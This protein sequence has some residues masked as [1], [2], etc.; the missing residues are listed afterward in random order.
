LGV[1]DSSFSSVAGFTLVEVLIALASVSVLVAGAAGLLS[2]ASVA[3]RSAR[4]ST[5][6]TLLAVQKV[7]QLG[8][9]PATPPGGT[10]HDYFAADGS[11]AAAASAVFIRRWTVTPA[12]AAS[13]SASVIVEVSVSGSG[14]AADVQAVVGGGGL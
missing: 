5:T 11:P 2:T 9:M 13:G 3:M 10:W 1:S 4:H 7:E 8:A 6:A 14:R 12:W